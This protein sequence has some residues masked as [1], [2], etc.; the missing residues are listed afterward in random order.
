MK[1]TTSAGLISSISILEIEILHAIRV[2][3]RYSPS[4]ETFTEFYEAGGIK[5]IEDLL[6]RSGVGAD[7]R[8]YMWSMRSGVSEESL[9]RRSK[10]FHVS[11]RLEEVD[12]TLRRGVLCFAIVDF[13]CST[14]YTQKYFD[15]ADTTLPSGLSDFLG[16]CRM[17]ATLI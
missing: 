17:Y 14:C 13:L 12:F 8:R 6:R 16:V 3:L 7:C 2:H 4:V 11:K 15:F 10:A 1:S 9:F 5:S